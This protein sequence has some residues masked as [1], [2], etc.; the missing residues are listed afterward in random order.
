MQHLRVDSMTSSK[1]GNPVINQ[2]LIATKEGEYFQSY[3]TLIAFRDWEGKTTLDINSWDYS[4]T[5][6]KYLKEF[7]G[8][9]ESKREIV[10]K[11]KQGVY[12]LSE[13][14]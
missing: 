6:L 5:T 13:L 11:I 7:L 9:S 1:S 12:V 8:T 4:K 3:R 2:Y 10:K 14:N